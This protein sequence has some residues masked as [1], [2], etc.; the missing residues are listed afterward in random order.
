MINLRAMHYKNH[1]AKG[2]NYPVYLSA[3]SSAENRNIEVKK[4]FTV[5]ADLRRELDNLYKR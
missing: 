5:N 1:A 2:D 4:E 3:V